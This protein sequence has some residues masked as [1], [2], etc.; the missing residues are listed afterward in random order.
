MGDI[1]GEFDCEKRRDEYT[2]IFEYVR[3][4][5]GEADRFFDSKRADFEKMLLAA[6]SGEPLRVWKSKAPYSACGFAF[7][8]DVLRNIDCKLSVVELP[9]SVERTDGAIES[10][11][12]WAEV[13]AGQIYKYLPL[14]REVHTIEKG[15]LSRL[16]HDLKAE[17]APLRALVNGKLISVPDDFYDH[18]IVKNIPDGEFVMARLIGTVLGTYALGVGDGWYA[19][20]IKKMIADNKLEI[21]EDKDASRPYGKVLRKASR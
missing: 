5:N 11:I 3:F 19:S 12:D 9:E 10:F 14:E 8:C 18:I 13:S 6:K 16:W 1:S 7:L 17:N 15:M 4:E 20:R 21:V 2:R